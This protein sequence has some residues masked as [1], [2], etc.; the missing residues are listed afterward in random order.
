MLIFSY[1]C[2]AVFFLFVCLTGL[3]VLKAYQIFMFIFET[4]NCGKLVTKTKLFSIPCGMFILFIDQK[5]KRNL[6]G[7]RLKVISLNMCR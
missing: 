5:P 1:F 2:V 4:A 6:L 3:M 7:T